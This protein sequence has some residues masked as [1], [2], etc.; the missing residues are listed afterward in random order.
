MHGCSRISHAVLVSSISLMILNTKK[1]KDC[2]ELRVLL[3]LTARWTLLLLLCAIRSVFTLTEQPSSSMMFLLP[4]FKFLVKALKRINILWHRIFLY[5]GGDG[6][7][8]NRRDFALLTAA[9]HLCHLHMFVDD[10]FVPSIEAHGLI[11]FYDH[12]AHEVV[13]DGVLVSVPRS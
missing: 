7:F 3:R 4:Y 13:G 5:P 2:G 11:W 10:A 12:E 1:N 9:Y 6:L 8:V